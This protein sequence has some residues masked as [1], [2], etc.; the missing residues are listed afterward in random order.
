M[1]FYEGAAEGHALGAAVV[2]EDEGAT[3][4]VTTPLT[5]QTVDATIVSL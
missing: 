5:S 4:L 1:P 2:G 3:V